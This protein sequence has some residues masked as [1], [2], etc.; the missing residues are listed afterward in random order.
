[1][2]NTEELV[3]KC[4]G[5]FCHCCGKLYDVKDFARA[6]RRFV[7]LEQA[8]KDKRVADILIAKTDAIRGV[9]LPEH[10]GEMRKV[11]SFIPFTER[12]SPEK[13]KLFKREMLKIRRSF[14]G[15]MKRN[16]KQ[17]RK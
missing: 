11:K 10:F 12:L 6:A 2:S 9:K 15:Q 7:R 1:M 13:L 3:R 8:E 4:F 16:N 14:Q 5:S 17:K